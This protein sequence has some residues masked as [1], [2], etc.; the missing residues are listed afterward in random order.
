MNIYQSLGLGIVQGIT[1]FLPVSS[2]AHLV[3]LQRL[4]NFKE[5][6]LLF[7]CFLHFST[8]LATIVFFWRKIEKIIFFTAEGKNLIKLVFLASLPTAFI[9]LLFRKIF[10]STFNSVTYPAFFLLVT[11]SL[12]WIA[13]KRFN[14]REEKNSPKTIVGSVLIVG[15]VQGFALLPGISRSGSTIATGIILGWSPT[16]SAEFSFLLSLPAIAGVTLIKLLKSEFSSLVK[17]FFIYLPGMFFSFI[18]GLLS[19]KLFW[20]S[21]LKHRWKIFS[22]YCWF[23]GLTVLILQFLRIF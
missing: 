19:L 10:E 4:F 5:A 7:D 23:L 17:E 15:M 8:L 14:L 18:F 16:F 9:G 12:L 20:Q 1:E 6:P 11:G 3:F 22:Y 2:S 21:L 13:N